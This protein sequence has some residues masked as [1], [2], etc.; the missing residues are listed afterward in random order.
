MAMKL[1]TLLIIFFFLN[2][3]AA[4]ADDTAASVNG[5]NVVFKKTNDVV[6]EWEDLN[7]SQ[8]NVS[9]EYRFKNLKES[10][11]ETMISFPLAEILDIPYSINVNDWKV[12]KDPINFHLLVNGKSH[13]FKI[14]VQK[15]KPINT[16]SFR[17]NYVW[18]QQF[19]GKQTTQISHQYKTVLGTGGLTKEDMK[20]YCIDQN[21]LKALEALK[22][23]LRKK[24]SPSQLK[25]KDGELDDYMHF[26]SFGRFSFILKTANNWAGPI[27]TF[28]LKIDKGSPTTLVSTCWKGLKS[29]S[30]T[31]LILEKKNLKPESDL[32]ILFVNEK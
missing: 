27:G 17:V 10:A 15:I 26:H 14:V 8:E 29:I 3:T 28:R 12:G 24:L 23:R 4:F 7:I 2:L 31:D 20:T 1:F 25:V 6:M 30:N 22:S 5:G 18:K 19:P 11:L 32:N 13:P 16:M 21:F 9:V